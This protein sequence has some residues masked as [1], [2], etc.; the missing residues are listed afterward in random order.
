M[1]LWGKSDKTAGRPTF[2]QLKADGTLAQDASGKKLVL[3]DN[4]EASL[5]ANKAKGVSSAGWYL[6]Q[7]NGDRVRAELLIALADAPRQVDGNVAD[8][9]DTTENALGVG[10]DP[11]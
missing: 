3:I 9:S 2:I 8:D 6:I 10:T 7:K 11:A 5:P 1:S 4:D